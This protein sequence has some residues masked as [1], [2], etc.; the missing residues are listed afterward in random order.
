MYLASTDNGLKD[1]VRD[2]YYKYT[3]DFSFS[4]LLNLK[5]YFILFWGEIQRDWK[6]NVFEMHDV[7]AER[8]N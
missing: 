2:L 6:M 5:L 8:I 7:K 4:F 3:T 1:T